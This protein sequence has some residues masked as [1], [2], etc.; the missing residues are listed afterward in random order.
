MSIKEFCL[1]NNFKFSEI[2]YVGEDI[3]CLDLPTNVEVS[4]CPK[5]SVQK[6]M[7]NNGIIKLNS[8]AG[9]G[10]FREFAE[11]YLQ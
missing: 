4:A 8:K 5:N 7:S 2:A 3:N 10:A 11:L 1:Y 6:V 9:E